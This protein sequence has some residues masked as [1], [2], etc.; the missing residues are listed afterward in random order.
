MA[1]V[2]LAT[3]GFPHIRIEPQHVHRGPESDASD[4]CQ[5]NER[6]LQ[7]SRHQMR[8]HGGSEIL[9]RLDCF[10]F[11]VQISVIGPVSNLGNAQPHLI[12]VK[13]MMRARIINF[14]AQMHTH[15]AAE[16]HQQA[17]CWT[18]SVLSLCERLEETDP[19]SMFLWCVL[20]RLLTA[21][22]KQ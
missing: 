8:C 22:D 21:A 20:L 5:G 11:G 10:R 18:C 7:Q 12:S 4:R 15:T 14:T 16:A 3:R 13:F 19:I 6:F 2:A 1:G 9:R 17:Q